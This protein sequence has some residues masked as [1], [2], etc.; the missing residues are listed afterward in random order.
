MLV[1]KLWYAPLFSKYDV[2]FHFRKLEQPKKNDELKF[3]KFEMK[4]VFNCLFV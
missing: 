1:E 4:I 3:T 2:V